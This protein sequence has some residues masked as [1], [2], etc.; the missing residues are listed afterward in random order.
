[1]HL[2]ACIIGLFII[3]SGPI[4]VPHR[5]CNNH[6]RLLKEVTIPFGATGSLLA[7]SP[8]CPSKCGSQ[9]TDFNKQLW[10]FQDATMIS[11]WSI[12]Y[13]TNGPILLQ[14]NGFMEFLWMLSVLYCCVCVQCIFN[15]YVVFYFD[16]PV[17]WKIKIAVNISRWGMHIISVHDVMQVCTRCTNLQ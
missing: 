2:C 16:Q 17:H 13:P 8:I 12:L 11:L 5:R 15:W 10:C 9:I 4:I 14:G 1:M 3:V 6:H 7:Q